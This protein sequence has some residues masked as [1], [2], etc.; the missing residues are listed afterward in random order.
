MVSYRMHRKQNGQGFRQPILDRQQGKCFYC[1]LEFGEWFMYR[2]RLICVK[3][4]WDHFVPFDSC[5][6]NKPSNFVAACHECN[7][8]KH[9]LIFGSHQEAIDYVRL[10][11]QQRNLPLCPV[12][13]SV[14]QK[15]EVAEV[16]QSRL[17]D[18]TFLVNA[19]RCQYCSR[20]VPPDR[21]KFCSRECLIEYG[22]RKESREAE[23]K[24]VAEAIR[25]RQKYCEDPIWP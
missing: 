13:E 24:R 6:H 16:L 1:G 3:V 5:R 18:Q 14:R 10:K 8:L 9:K 11:R 21:R 19:H 7:S 12:R 15:K 17:P 2:N 25:T 23:A 20:T 22:L 4:T